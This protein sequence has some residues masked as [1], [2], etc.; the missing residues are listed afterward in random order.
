MEAGREL[1]NLQCLSCHTI[2]GF[3]NDVVKRSQEYTYLGILSM[4]NGQ[5]KIR[6]Y[7]P[8]IAGTQM[9]K[10]ALAAYISGKLLGKETVIKKEP[11]KIEKLAD[12]TTSFDTKKD[13]YILLVW[14]DLGM[15]CI[16]DSDPWFVILP[17]A[18]TLEAQLIKRG[19]LPEII[20][21]G[22]QLQ[23]QAIPESPWFIFI[24]IPGNMKIK[25][26]E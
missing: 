6:N 11:Y 23:Y 8:P 7:M 18:N 5:G 24:R 9:E 2:N 21:E 17:P 12:L 20:S 16:S 19:P 1:F 10:E 15:H 26:L 25:I 22:V 4:L 14:N 13:D 3:R